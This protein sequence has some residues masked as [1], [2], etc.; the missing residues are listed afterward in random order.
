RAAQEDAVD[1][2]SGRAGDAAALADLH[3]LVDLRGELLLLERGLELRQIDA[4]LNGP[5]LEVVGPELTLVLE[6]EHV[7]L[8][9]SLVAAD[10]EH[11]LG[12]HVRGLR[13]FVEG[14]GVV[15]P[16]DAELV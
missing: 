12:R 2:R 10:A 8:P 15:L 3:V 5:L 13:L 9:E 11:R 7:E 4:R 6:R 1:D 14:K 16:D